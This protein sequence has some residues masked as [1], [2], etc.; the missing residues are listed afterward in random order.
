MNAIRLLGEKIDGRCAKQ[1]EMGSIDGRCQ[2]RM[3]AIE[4]KD[5]IQIGSLASTDR[6]LQPGQFDKQKPLREG[7]IFLQEPIA[8][9]GACGDGQQ[10]LLVFESQS[11]DRGST[12]G[13]ASGQRSL[14]GLYH[15]VQQVGHQL[16]IHGDGHPAS[17]EKDS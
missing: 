15:N 11:L 7:E 5:E 12:E 14:P 9:K 13:N 3:A 8:P 17:P 6:R 2:L 10:G 4:K 1:V 16:L